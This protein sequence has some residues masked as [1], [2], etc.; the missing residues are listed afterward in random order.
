MLERGFRDRDFIQTV[1][2]FLFCVIGS[3]HPVDRIISYLKY[4]PD[5]EGLWFKGGKRFNRVMRYYTM[6]DLIGTF[7][8]LE[9]YPEYL[10][11]SDVMGIRISAVP[12]SRILVHFKP[13]EKI[14]EIAN[15]DRLDHLQSKALNLALMISDES[16]VPLEYFG[17]T[18][19]I[20]LDIHQPFSDIDLTVYG[21]ENSMRVKEALKQIYS[22]NRFGVRRFNDEEAREW[23]LNKSKMYPLTYGEAKALLDRK[24]NR[25]VFRET[26]FSI[27]PVKLERDIEEGYGDKIFR[28]EGMIRVEAAVTDDSEAD[29][30]PSIYTVEDVE[31]LE[32]P[33]VKDIREIVSYEGLYG[34]LAGKGEGI[35]AYGKLERVTDLRRN[36]EYYRILIGSQE[37]R[38]RD[39]I[40]PL[41]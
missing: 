6:L 41:L 12:L 25:G 30:M 23:C 31:V 38:G 36:E 9:K 19:S 37:A 20:L 16:G 26:M 22:S 35:E 34:G 2:G 39:Y 15:S 21:V 40:K 27:H 29:F 5:E 33:P 24:W 32:G 11:D 17:V 8:F 13:E 18:G 14:W 7:N 4:V 1:E 28:F 10:Y 3:V